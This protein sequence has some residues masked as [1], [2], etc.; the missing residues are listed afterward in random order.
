MA[1]SLLLQLNF[2]FTKS[3]SCLWQCGSHLFPCL[4]LSSRSLTIFISG[5]PA[6]L[7]HL[8]RSRQPSRLF[9]KRFVN[10]VLLVR[11]QKSPLYSGCAFACLSS[12]SSTS[13][14]CAQ[15]SC[16]F[17]M[18]INSAVCLDLSVQS[19]EFEEILYLLIL[20][21]YMPNL[22]LYL[23]AKHTWSS[24]CQEGLASIARYQACTC[25]LYYCCPA[26]ESSFRSSGKRNVA[27]LKQLSADTGKHSPEDLK[28]SNSA[29]MPSHHQSYHNSL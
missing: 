8:S 1:F 3:R 2:D 11:L 5:K 28:R 17:F 18:K 15:P 27:Y 22:S 25:L 14:T 12:S 26:L 21:V 16:E 9:S 19:Q 13:A 23:L 10:I 20:P 4:L 7:I 29:M 24:Q 6:S